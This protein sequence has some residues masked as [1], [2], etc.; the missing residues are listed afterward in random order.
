MGKQGGNDRIDI[1]FF[2]QLLRTPNRWDTGGLQPSGSSSSWP[3][4]LAPQPMRSLISPRV[5]SLLLFAGS[6]SA[7]PL[8]SYLEQ[9]EGRVLVSLAKLS[10][11]GRLSLGTPLLSHISVSWRGPLTLNR[12]Q[13]L[14]ALTEGVGRLQQ[15]PWPAHSSHS[16]A[17]EP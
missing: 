9:R 2:A 6:A 17:K 5:A 15:C 8:D 14:I 16:L 12:A 11:S 7:T 3:G 10:L 1:I 13:D 4:T